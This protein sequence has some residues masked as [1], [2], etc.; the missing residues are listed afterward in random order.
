MFERL[1]RLDLSRSILSEEVVNCFVS[2]ISSKGNLLQKLDLTGCT[3]TKA[4]ILELE[5]Y[6]KKSGHIIILGHIDDLSTSSASICTS[7]KCCN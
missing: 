4:S 6:N 2:A 7:F 1:K 3:L 5:E